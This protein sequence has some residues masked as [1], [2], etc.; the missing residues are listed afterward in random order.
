MAI[1]VNAALAYVANN[2]LAW[3]LLPFL[4]DDFNRVL[5]AVNA[6]LA[7]TI[8]VNLARLFY[9][10][11]WFVTATDLVSTAVGLVATI[12]MYR[13]F[14]FDFESSEIPWDLG[15]RAILVIAMVGSV[16]G[17]AVGAFRLGSGQRTADT[18]TVIDGADP[19]RARY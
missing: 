13:V 7:V 5:P 14:P 8:A 10:P 6:T 2:I 18:S 16:I 9:D 17:L 12:R 15:V 4:T 1:V 11:K 19:S 3:D